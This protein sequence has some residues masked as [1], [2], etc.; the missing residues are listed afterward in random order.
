M[1]P[2]RRTPIEKRIEAIKNLAE[3]QRAARLLDAVESAADLARGP[4][5]SRSAHWSEL[6]RDRTSDLEE[7]LRVWG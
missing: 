6:L 4:N 2:A 3:R 5:R 7:H 1:P